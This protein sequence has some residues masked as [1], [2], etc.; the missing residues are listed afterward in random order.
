M[1]NL[2]SIWIVLVAIVLYRQRTGVGAANVFPLTLRDRADRQM[3]FSQPARRVV[4][5]SRGGLE[6]VLVLGGHAVGQPLLR[7]DPVPEVVRALPI[8]GNAEIL[9][10]TVVRRATL[11]VNADLCARTCFAP[12]E[13]PVEVGLA[14]L[15]APYFF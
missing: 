9:S 3:T 4:A 11:V 12:L 7:G 8:I 15:G 6:I 5:L 10:A 13:L 1:M 2:K 14:L